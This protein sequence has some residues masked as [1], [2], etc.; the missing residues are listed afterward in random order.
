[1]AEFAIQPTVTQRVRA[2]LAAQGVAL[3]PWAPLD[4]V[5][6]ELHALLRRERDAPGFWGPLEELL[7]HVVES[8]VDPGWA[9]RLPAPQAE[10]LSAADVGDL[11]RELRAALRGA[12]EGAGVE[13]VRRF[14]GGVSAA[15]L[16]GFLLMGVAVSGCS[17]DEHLVAPGAGE[18]FATQAVDAAQSQPGT[19]AADAAP[20]GADRVAADAA[21]TAD[22]R[23][24]ARPAADAD[25]PACALDRASA[26]WRAIDSSARDD[27]QKRALCECLAGASPSW[28]EGLTRLFERG[29]PE[30]VAAAL[31]RLVEVCAQEG[32]L[33]GDYS[34]VDDPALQP[35]QRQRS[36]Q[37]RQRRRPVFIPQVAYRGVTF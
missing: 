3:A 24:D 14:T 13:A 4:E 12:D 15:V 36:L 21:P 16:A 22:A 2:F 11:T 32:A 28:S 25:A 35:R 37:P 7:G 20:A 29:T 10:L 33:D 5:Y 31:D 19:R 23:A 26:L 9:G 1:M 34:A 18:T 27:P 6:V 30:Q 8:A 17:D